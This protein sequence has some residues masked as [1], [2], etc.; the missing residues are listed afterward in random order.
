MRV[1]SPDS[2]T[3]LAHSS[4]SDQQRDGPDAEHTRLRERLW[5]PHARRVLTIAFFA[6]VG[7]LLFT[8][9]RTIEWSKVL[10]SMRELP[11]QALLLAA[12]TAYSSYALYSCFDLLGRRLTGHRLPA[13]TVLAITFV[14]YAFNLNL[15]SLVGAFAFRYRLYSHYALKN[16]I[17]TRVLGFSMLTNWLGYFFV[18]GFA[19]AIWP[20]Q[21]PPDWKIDSG[22]LRIVGAVLLAAAVAYVICSARWPSRTWTV[23]GHELVLPN[24]RMAVL[25]LTMASINW[26]LIGTTVWLLLQQ[27]IDFSAVLSVLLV[28]AVAGLLAHVPAGLGVLEAVFIALLSHAVPKHE[29]LG[30]LLAYRAIYYLLPLGAA[31]V[32]YLV[33]EAR[34]KQGPASHAADDRTVD[35]ARQSLR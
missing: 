8:H 30:A 13:P 1:V 10:T 14:S 5:W 7:Y 26:L 21:L 28:A 32:V 18:A 35:S 2:P 25:Q 29:L 15:G 22:G 11:K 31:L 20:L 4:A 23:R 34:A 12:V 3:E 19:F 27:R 24:F 33:M 16:G 17:I 6:L 9:G